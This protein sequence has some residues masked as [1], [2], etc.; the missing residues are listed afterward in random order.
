MKE[1]KKNYHGKCFQP[2]RQRDYESL[3]NQKTPFEYNKVL[4]A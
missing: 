3:F 4:N 1:N 2:M